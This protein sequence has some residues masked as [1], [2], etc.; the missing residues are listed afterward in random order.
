VKKGTKI[1]DEVLEKR[2]VQMDISIISGEIMPTQQSVGPLFSTSFTHWQ[3]T[4]VVYPSKL[5][6]ETLPKILFSTD[7]LAD[8][9]SAA[10][11]WIR[12]AIP[13]P[14]RFCPLRLNIEF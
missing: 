14:L 12:I 10:P 4:T 7:E 6:G 2:D 9:S 13:F 1:G 3:Y 11:P 5:I 8:I